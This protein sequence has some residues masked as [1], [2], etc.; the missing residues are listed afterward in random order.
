MN[1]GYLPYL[2]DAASALHPSP[3]FSPFPHSRLR[4]RCSGSGPHVNF[5]KKLSF[6]TVATKNSFSHEHLLY[7]F[8]NIIKERAESRGHPLHLLPGHAPCPSPPIHSC[9]RLSLPVPSRPSLSS[10]VPFCPLPPRN[11]S[12]ETPEFLTSCQT[13]DSPTH[14]HT[15][16]PQ[17]TLP[18]GLLPEG[19]GAM[20]SL[21]LMPQN[22]VFHV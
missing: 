13:P 18:N 22:M 4:L 16:L 12:R 7:A 19:A 3:A 1:D 8:H 10:P 11:L 5:S 9:P 20:K 14:V 2:E 15:P 21:C 6:F 17:S